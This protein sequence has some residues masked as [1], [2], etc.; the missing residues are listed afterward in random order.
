[1][2]FIR[3]RTKDQIEQRQLDILK[4]CDILFE[5]GGYEKVNIKAVAEMTTITRSSIYTYYKTKDE[6]M[7]DLLSMELCEWK[8]ELMTWCEKTAP[9]QP[10]E[11]SCQF[12]EI[13]LH[14]E[15]LLQHYCLLYTLLEKNCR[16]EKMVAF[17]KRVIPVQEA[18]VQIFMT[19]I[20]TL[21]V[22]TAVCVVEQMIA[23][24]IGLYPASHL[25]RKQEQA[26]ALSETG[27]RP[28]EFR[29]LCEKGIEAFLQAVL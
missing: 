18:L 16:L 13:L 27:Y 10:K 19:N 14:H 24:I 20:P 11:F 4:A 12:T 3:A 15:K 6:M 17:K 29:K 25:T 9:L 8:E 2:D 22:E 26:I 1:M 28:P 7:M 23:Y 5:E 21:S